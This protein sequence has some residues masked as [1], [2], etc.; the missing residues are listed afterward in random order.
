MSEGKLK[1]FTGITI[2]LIWSI[3][4]VFRIIDL[5]D[6]MASGY[7]QI[8]GKEIDVTVVQRADIVDI[9][10][11]ALLIICGFSVLRKTRNVW[12]YGSIMIVLSKLISTI[13]HY[14]VHDPEFM[15]L[16]ITSFI[17]PSG[18][19]LL[20]FLSQREQP[21]TRRV[22]NTIVQKSR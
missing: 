15:I 18:A 12:L 17:F 11:S 2:I 4:I 14:S 21:V 3:T 8:D 5:L 20:L 19:L 7:G 1:T 16:S 6:G 22:N 13:M 9:V 10:L